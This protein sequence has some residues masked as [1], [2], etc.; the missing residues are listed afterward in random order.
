MVQPAPQSVRWHDASSKQYIMQPPGQVV[1][2]QVEP[3]AQSV[4][5]APLVHVV[6]H[7]EPSRQVE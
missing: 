7:S 5:Q 6:S 2:V 4:R 3:V 1:V